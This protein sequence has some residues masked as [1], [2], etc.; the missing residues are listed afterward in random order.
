MKKAIVRWLE[1]WKRAKDLLNLHPI[2]KLCGVG[3]MDH[4]RMMHRFRE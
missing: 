2:C 3:K 1:V 4:Y